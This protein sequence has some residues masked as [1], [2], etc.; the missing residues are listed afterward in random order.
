MYILYVFKYFFLYTSKFCLGTDENYD[1]VI[2]PTSP[3]KEINNYQVQCSPSVSKWNVVIDDENLEFE[4]QANDEDG[5]VKR[6]LFQEC[7]QN[8]LGRY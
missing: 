3:V 1:I 7:K 5:T 2:P 6:V 8:K 4:K